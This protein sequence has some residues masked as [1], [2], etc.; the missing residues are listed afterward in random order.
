M[1]RA[2]VAA[3]FRSGPLRCWR[4]VGR[5]AAPGCTRAQEPQ[6][7]LPGCDAGRVVGPRPRLPRGSCP[8][9]S[10]PAP[11][12]TEEGAVWGPHVQWLTPPSSLWGR[13][14]WTTSCPVLRAGLSERSVL[15]ALYVA[16]TATIS[17]ACAAQ[18]CASHTPNGEK[19]LD[20]QY[21]TDHVTRGHKY[22]GFLRNLL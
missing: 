15:R 4:S 7:A 22:L 16:R 14:V 21:K 9:T 18:I 2:C 8:R 6:G 1:G 19:S 12:R 3:V 13:M 5:P 11:I 10:C 17:Q 20:Y